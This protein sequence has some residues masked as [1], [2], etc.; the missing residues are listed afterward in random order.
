MDSGRK[1]SNLPWTTL[2]KP[3]PQPAS[4]S[5]NIAVAESSELLTN[6]PNPFNPSTTIEYHVETDAQVSVNV[7]DIT[8]KLVTELVSG[9]VPAGSHNVA[10]NA[11]D[12]PSGVYFVAL[13][14]GAQTSYRRMVLMK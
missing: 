9:D 13:Q 6:Y 1:S 7:Y 14:V 2:I 11:A 8:G 12:M 4:E 10:W 3:G 5:T